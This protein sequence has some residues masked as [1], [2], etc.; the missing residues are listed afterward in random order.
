MPEISMTL[1]PPRRAGDN[2]Y[3]IVTLTHRSPLYDAMDAIKRRQ[4]ARLLHV[5]I[6]NEPR[7]RPK[8]DVDL[9]Y[10]S[11]GAHP[12][13]SPM[14]LEKFVWFIDN[15]LDREPWAQC[16]HIVRGNTSTYLNLPLLE[17]EIARLPQ[18]KCYAGN[19]DWGLFIS[20]R[21]IIF[22]R[23]VAKQFARWYRLRW[24]LKSTIADDLVIGK[25]M[26][27]SGIGMINMPTAF[28]DRGFVPPDGAIAEILRRAPLVRVRNDKDREGIDLPIWRA[29]E[30]VGEAMR[31]E[32]VA[33][34]IVG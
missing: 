24:W 11:R 22:S 20:G 18:Q 1:P 3:G 2:R 23:D 7:D 19:V 34:P 29:L 15:Y 5:F 28:L 6:Y 33:P 26:R 12:I 27:R 30:R 17:R 4:Y 32:G 8:H 13:G 9:I 10:V 14:M 25:A 31:S 21:C 16:T